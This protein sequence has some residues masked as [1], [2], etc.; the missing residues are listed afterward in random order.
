MPLP[1]LCRTPPKIAIAVNLL[2][3][4]ADISFVTSKATLKT[5]CGI[6]LLFAAVPAIAQANTIQFVGV[7]TGVNDGRYYVLPYEISIDGTNQ[8]VTCYDF[9]DDVNVGDIWQAQL[10]NPDQ[11]AA[12]GFFSG[13]GEGGALADYE[14]VAWL[15]AQTYTTSA[16]QIG[17]QYAIWNV[18]GMYQTTAESLTYSDAATAAAASG[19]RGFDFSGVRFIQQTGAVAGQSGTEQA[20]V[21]WEQPSQV[22]GTSLDA[23]PEPSSAL[24]LPLGLLALLFSKRRRSRCQRCAFIC[25]KVASSEGFG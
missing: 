23:V 20:F 10:L 21:F 13:E 9:F 16:Q 19:Y 14:R 17:L 5:V 11:G 25:S 3:T 24:L 15:D 18:F 6:S 4:S 22:P 7:P 2:S 12:S 1:L 8:L